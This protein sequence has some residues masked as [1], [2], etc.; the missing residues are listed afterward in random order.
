MSRQRTT[1][2]LAL[3]S[4]RI[5]AAIALAV[6][7]CSTMADCAAVHRGGDGPLPDTDQLRVHRIRLMPEKGECE[8]DVEN[9]TRGSL[10]VSRLRFTGVIHTLRIRDEAGRCFRLKAPGR[11]SGPHILTERLL[12]AIVLPPRSRAVIECWLYRDYT[13][14]QVDAGQET[15]VSW[16]EIRGPARFTLSG[17]VGP[18]P[19]TEGAPQTV[20][21]SGEGE[22]IVSPPMAK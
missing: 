8:V 1:H 6:F 12:E 4:L 10:R 21:V 3:R 19:P 7:L 15:P 2:A 17:V 22:V 20:A 16:D 9:P 18:P 13:L 11:G 5:A 14:V